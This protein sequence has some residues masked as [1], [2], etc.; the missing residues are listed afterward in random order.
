[1]RLFLVVALQLHKSVHVDLVL[2][3]K[4]GLSRMIIEKLIGSQII[5]TPKECV[6]KMEMCAVCAVCKP[7]AV[8]IRRQLIGRLKAS[9]PSRVCLD[10]V[11]KMPLKEAS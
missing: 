9:E 5:L 7:H 4:P 6:A 10:Q 3:G 1:M 2:E 8:F 11:L